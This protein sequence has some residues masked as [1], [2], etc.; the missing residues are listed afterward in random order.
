MF[1]YNEL[2]MK[3]KLIVY[4][5]R[6]NIYSYIFSKTN[7]VSTQHGYYEILKNIPDNS[8]ILDVGVGEGI[9]FTNLKVSNLIKIKNLSIY[10]IDIDEERIEIAKK[11]IKE[12][13]LDKYVKCEKKYICELNKETNGNGNGN[14]AGNG[15]GNGA[16]NGEF[17]YVFYIESFPVI[18]INIFKQFINISKNLINT[19]GTVIL[20]HT[21]EPESNPIIRW[22]KPYLHLLTLNDFG[23]ECTLEQMHNYCKEWGCQ[24]E[25]NPCLNTTYGNAL[26]LLKYIPIVNNYPITTYT[27][28]LKINKVFN[29]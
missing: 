6:S 14:G 7:P 24:Y 26:E 27:V 29:I 22:F 15:N 23:P 1:K 28:E 9:Y 3:F 19:N 11:R 17:D 20:Y 18:P 8:K 12:S 4:M 16:G 13:E 21:L 5:I 25:I 10:G 2:Y